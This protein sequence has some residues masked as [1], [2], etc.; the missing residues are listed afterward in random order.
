MKLQIETYHGCN[1]RCSVCTIDQWKRTKGPID[2]ALFETIITQALDLMP[3]LEVISLY[4]DGEP[5]LDKKIAERIAKCKELRL[6]H[7]GF[8]SNGSLLTRKAAYDVLKAGMDWI[9]IS[10]DSMDA[11]SYEGNRI[12]LNHADVVANIHGL[13]EERKSL[14]KNLEISLRFLDFPGNNQTFSE[15]KTYWE[16]YLLDTDKIVYC[17]C[18]NWGEGEAKKVITT[19]C[20]HPFKNMVVLNNGVVPMC[21]VD[22]NAETPMGTVPDQTLSEIWNG[23]LFKHIRMHHEAGTRDRIDRCRGCTVFK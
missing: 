4:M 2:D 23:E 14:N 20:I 7:V 13:I 9:A 12:G 6:P 17:P 11:A 21:C 15:Y 8:S 16:Q 19:K 3:N 22:Y 10:L 1:A 5:F 18:H